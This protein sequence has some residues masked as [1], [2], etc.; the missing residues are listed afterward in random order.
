MSTD[1]I[2]LC[3]VSSENIT[4]EWLLA[5]LSANSGF[6]AEIVEIYRDYWQPKSWSIEISTITGQPHLFLFGPGGFSLRL[7]PRLL[8]MYHMMHFS[9][10]A[11]DFFKSRTALRR[12]C[13]DIADLVGSSHAIYT[14]ELMPHIGEDLQ[15]IESWLRK[16][17]GPPATNFEE[18][19]KA[20]LFGPRAWYIDRFDDL[21]KPI[22]RSGAE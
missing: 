15:E 2:A 21:G 12:A 4:A 19:H 3:G 9:D 5:E 16:E 8:E 10:F 13:L 14:H 20:D 1:F 6:A 17:I 7:K 22:H 11:S 18:L